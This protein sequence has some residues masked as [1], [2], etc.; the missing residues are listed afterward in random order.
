MKASKQELINFI[1]PPYVRTMN[2]FNLHREFR[3]M[4]TDMRRREFFITN[5]SVYYLLF[6]TDLFDKTQADS[7]PYDNKIIFYPRG[8]HC[9][10][11]KGVFVFHKLKEIPSDS[12]NQLVIKQIIGFE[13][14]HSG[15]VLNK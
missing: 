5:Q 7:Y 3:S 14:E 9:L 12:F 15:L 8:R 1:P 2:K 10:T 11:F 6:I 13:Q 4:L